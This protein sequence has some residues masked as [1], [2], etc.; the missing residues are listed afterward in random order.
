M[1]SALIEC[2]RIFPRS[3]I[4]SPLSA[5]ISNVGAD[6]VGL[7]ECQDANGIAAAS[8]YSVVDSSGNGNTILYKANRL[9]ALSSGRFNVP[10]D[11]SLRCTLF[12]IQNDQT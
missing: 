4:L 12:I 10:R 11:V 5:H 8:G 7:Q 3:L 2:F 1:L 9:E 6:V